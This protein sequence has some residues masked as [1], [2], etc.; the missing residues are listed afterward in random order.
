MPGGFNRD[1]KGRIHARL[2]LGKA[3]AQKPDF[4]SEKRV[5]PMIRIGFL[6]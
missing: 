6:G 4:T 1:L 3:I 2:R 5:K